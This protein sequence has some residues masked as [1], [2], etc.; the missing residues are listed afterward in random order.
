MWAPDACGTAATGEIAIGTIRY[1][2]DGNDNEN[3]NDEWGEFTNPGS[4]VL[5][6]TGWT[7]TDE[8]ASVLHHGHQCRLGKSSSLC[9][10]P[11]WG[12]NPDQ[13]RRSQPAR[14]THA[15]FEGLVCG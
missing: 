11:C 10:P 3:L 1:D 4:S 14:L 5:D 7:V 8:S 12:R 9:E 6:L 15:Q 2:A 13:I